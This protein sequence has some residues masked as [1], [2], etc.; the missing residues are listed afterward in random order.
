MQ[1]QL[2]HKFEK[3]NIH[4]GFYII[5]YMNDNLRVALCEHITHI[6][7]HLHIYLITFKLFYVQTSSLV[8]FCTNNVLIKSVSGFKK[9]NQD[10]GIHFQAL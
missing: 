5:Q 9:K 10:P 8:F 3:K 6:P 1:Y 2:E 7:I 4:D